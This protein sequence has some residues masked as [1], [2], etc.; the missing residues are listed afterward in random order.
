ME[1]CELAREIKQGCVIKHKYLNWVV[2]CIFTLMGISSIVSFDALAKTNAIGDKVVTIEA[3]QQALEKAV[4]QQNA[5]LNKTLDT[6]RDDVR[7]ITKRLDEALA[8]K[9]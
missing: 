7:Y 2:A 8:K 1:N 3:N 5:T 9:P 4:T 6:M